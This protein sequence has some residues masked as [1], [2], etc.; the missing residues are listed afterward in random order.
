MLFNACLSKLNVKNKPEL[1]NESISRIESVNDFLLIYKFNAN[2]NAN[3]N[4]Y[5]NNDIEFNNCTDT[6]EFLFISFN[7]LL[8]FSCCYLFYFSNTLYNPNY[9]Y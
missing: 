8:L 1:N 3:L 5:S 9:D 4:L 2:E 7:N 6:N